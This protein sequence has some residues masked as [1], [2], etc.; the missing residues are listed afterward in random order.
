MVSAKAAGKSAASDTSMDAARAF[1]A[2]GMAPPSSPAT[3]SA[4]LRRRLT[5]TGVAQVPAS[6]ARD[7]GAA[8]SPAFARRLGLVVWDNAAL[9]H[10]ATLADP[11]DA[12]TLRRVVLEDGQAGANL[13]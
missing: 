13:R 3:R 12:R 1:T 6:R 9:L 5:A 11:D 7:L 2:I 8:Q 10:S 4:S